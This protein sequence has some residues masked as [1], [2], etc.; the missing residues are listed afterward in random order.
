MRRIL[1]DDNLAALASLPA[2]FARLAYIDPPFNTGAQQ[3]TRVRGLR[4]AQPLRA[5]ASAVRVAPFLCAAMTSAASLAAQGSDPTLEKRVE[6]LEG[7][8]A[9]SGGPRGATAGYDGGFFIAS[10]DGSWRL[11]VGGLLQMNAVAFERGLEDR[12]SDAYLRRMRLEFRGELGPRLRFNLEPNFTE[13]QAELAEAWFGATLFDQRG[14][15]H[16]GR[17]KEP[18]GGEETSSRRHS[19]FPEYS[20]LNQF[21]PAEDTGLILLGSDR[22]GRVGYGLG[23]TSGDGGDP[24]VADEDVAARLTLQPFAGGTGALAG[25]RLGAAATW[26]RADTSIAGESLNLETRVPFLTFEPGSS[27]DGDVLRAG[28]ETLWYHG[29]LAASAELLRVEQD[30]S[31]AAGS[32]NAQSSGWTAAL[33]WVLTGEERTRRGVTPAR[34]V[35]GP[36]GGAGAWQLALRYSELSLDDDLETF[37]LVASGAH[38]GSVS[39]TDVGLNWYLSSVARVKLHWVLSRYERELT[40]GGNP[41]SGE[42]ALFAQFQMAF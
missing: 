19:D 31:G 27:H 26:G 22:A 25:L 28:L 40:L 10:E 38:P 6:V 14:L 36:A 29:P 4:G 8:A 42:Q 11:N 15:L 23:V 7:Q 5:R 37:G 20:L 24:L 32:T 16:V 9:Q 21:S 18:F 41:R 30:V 17:M 2:G 34:P 12:D 1:C 35:F 39:S 33:T 13:R 3:H